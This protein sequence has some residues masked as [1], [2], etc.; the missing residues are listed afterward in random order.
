M[1]EALI[2][3]IMPDGHWAVEL[4]EQVNKLSN[5]M[6]KV[7]SMKLRPYRIHF[8]VLVTRFSPSN[9]FSRISPT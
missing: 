8:E 2:L 4:H 6:I 5:E 1:C 7:S 3:E 9:E